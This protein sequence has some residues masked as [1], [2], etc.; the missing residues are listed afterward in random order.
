MSKLFLMAIICAGAL[1]AQDITGSIAG[2]VRDASGAGVPGAK[3]TVTAT[4]QNQVVRTATSDASGNYSAPLLAVGKYSV[5][6]EAPGFKKSTQTDINL[7]V[8]DQLTVNVKL[9]VGDV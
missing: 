1:V 9:E 2:T 8:N 3:V 6:V 5:S 4:E 7:N